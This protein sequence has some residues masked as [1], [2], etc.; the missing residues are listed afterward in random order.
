MS[1]SRQEFHRFRD[2]LMQRSGI[3]LSDNKQ[4]LVNN[5]LRPLIVEAGVDSLSDL[6]S[7]IDAMPNNDLAVKAVDAMTTNETFWFRDGSHFHYLENKLFAELS[8][9]GSPL[10]VWSAACSSG[11]EPYSIS[12]SF[13][14]YLKS[15]GQ[16]S[17]LKIT[18]TD[19]SEN[20]LKRAREGIY[21]ELEL[22]RGLPNELKHSDFSGIK[23]GWQISRAHRSAVS[24]SKINLLGDLSRLGQFDIVFCRNVLLYFSAATKLD[25]LQRI[26]QT[27]KLGAYLFLSSSEIIPAELNGLQTIRVA[28]C[29]CYRKV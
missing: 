11:Q 26:I 9:L 17:Q 27:M 2:F 19:L 21:A 16:A 13:N 1:I 22:S 15:G 7:L 14:K 6:L 8:R 4:Y 25:I 28:G 23:E 29:K 24:F 10:R 18:A 5:R 12:L 20:I 3:A